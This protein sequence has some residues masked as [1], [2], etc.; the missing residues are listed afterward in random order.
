MLNLLKN[1]YYKLEALKGCRLYIFL[2][3]VFAIFLVIGLA[4]G[5]FMGPKKD[6]EVGLIP[7]SIE[8]VPEKSYEGVITY[9]DPQNYPLDN[10]SFYLADDKGKEI[11]LLKANDQKLE[12]AEGHRVK[13][14]G[15][16]KKTE[17][18]KKD[19]LMVEKVVIPNAS[20]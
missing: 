15:A 5:V 9:I 16:L 20:N 6:S 11:I 1:I 4:A 8:T 3:V 2:A 17:D 18:G 13:V 7:K 19:I 12:V 14:Y 10:I